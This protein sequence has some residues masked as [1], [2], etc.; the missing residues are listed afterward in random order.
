MGGVPRCRLCLEAE[1]I[2]VVLSLLNLLKL[3]DPLLNVNQ[4]KLKSSVCER[5]SVYSGAY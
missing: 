4:N 3:T 5:D 1:C 2:F